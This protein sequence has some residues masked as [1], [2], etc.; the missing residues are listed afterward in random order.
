MT[1]SRA[2]N[3]SGRTSSIGSKN[4]RNGP[5]GNVYR[6]FHQQQRSSTWSPWAQE[7]AV[8]ILHVVKVL[9]IAAPPDITFEA[10][11]E[12]IGPGSELPAASRF[13]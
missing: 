3:G 5:R 12:E 8:H 6:K 11:L 4:A 2:T 9:Q 13:R 7:E 1:G 10:V